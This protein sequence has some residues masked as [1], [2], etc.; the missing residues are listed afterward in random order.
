MK[1]SLFSLVLLLLLIIANYYFF[2]LF[3]AINYFEWYYNEGPLI[4]LS[5]AFIAIIWNDFDKN[6]NLISANPAKYLSGCFW[7]I[8]VIFASMSTNL[9]RALLPSSANKEK[10]FVLRL[11]WDSFFS[12]IIYFILFI[13]TSLWLLVVAPPLY[14]IY[15]VAGAPVR[16]GLL[17]PILVNIVTS[18]GNTKVVKEVF[19]DNKESIKNNDKNAM[20]VS[21]T[22]KPVRLTA[23]IAA[24]LIWLVMLA[25]NYFF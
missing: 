23:S 8:A 5:V 24:I 14:F 9:S 6:I 19:S 22:R 16:M 17:N 11:L 13:I 20:D 3:L 18:T 25:V 4:S 21:F 12:L 15:L 7:V 2:S 1:K 10:P